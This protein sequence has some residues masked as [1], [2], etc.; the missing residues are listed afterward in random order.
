[1][2]ALLKIFFEDLKNLSKGQFFQK[3]VLPILVTFFT[4]GLF[5]HLYLLTFKTSSLISNTGEVVTISIRHEI[6][7]GRTRYR[8]NTLKFGLKNFQNE[9][10][11]RNEFQDYFSNLQNQIATGD[12]ISLFTISK[13]QTFLCWGKQNDIYEINKNG[14]KLFGIENVKEYRRNQT[15]IFG[16]L[17][18]LLWTW[19][20]LYRKYSKGK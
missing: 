1:M 13:L 12:T 8:Y 2:E 16:V 15:I 17:G 20:L 3:Y 10:R 11:L 14:I 6:G 7:G 19:Y 4:W 5:G 9:F 18:L